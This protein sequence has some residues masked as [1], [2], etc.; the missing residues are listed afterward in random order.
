MLPLVLAATAAA[1]TAVATGAPPPPPD[2]DAPPKVRSGFEVGLAVGGAVG[3][4]SGYPNNSTQIG[5]PSYYS[6]SGWMIGTSEEVLAMGALADYLSF[7]FWFDHSEYSNADWRSAANAGGLRIEVFPLVDL[8][9]RWNGLALL[10]QFGIGGGS[11]VSNRADLPQAQGT[12]SFV[13]AG[14]FYEWSFWR[15]PGG[16]FAGGPSL[17]YD[18]IWSQAFERHGLVAS[19]RVVFYGG[20]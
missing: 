16:H 5:N 1:A 17:E 4:A 20:P 14:A 7:G 6:A 11:L 19:A 15:G 8:H 13:G 10:A 12:Q 2:F 9:P 3:S 18:A